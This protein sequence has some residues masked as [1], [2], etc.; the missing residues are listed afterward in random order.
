MHDAGA[1][2]NKIG[3]SLCY[4]DHSEACGD[5][6]DGWRFCRARSGELPV[7]SSEYPEVKSI[8]SSEARRAKQLVQTAGK[9]TERRHP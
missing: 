6:Q 4:T 5:L 9:R 8:V 7:Q 2:K 1:G 3:R